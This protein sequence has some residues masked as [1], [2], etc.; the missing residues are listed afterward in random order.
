MRTFIPFKKALLSQDYYKFA[1]EVDG[2]KILVD[3][4][5]KLQISAVQVEKDNKSCLLIS[6]HAELA[7]WQDRLKR[8]G[9]KPSVIMSIDFLTSVVN[10]RNFEE[11]MI[12]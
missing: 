8:I 7:N 12:T 10:E 6:P 3:V 5:S 1:S 4:Y 2:V 11:K 9:P